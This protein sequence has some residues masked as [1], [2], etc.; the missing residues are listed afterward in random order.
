[1]AIPIKETPVLYGKDAESFLMEAEKSE[2][3]KKDI[4]ERE[5]IMSFFDKVS[6]SSKKS[7]LNLI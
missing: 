2:K 6:S 1:M 5:R 4:S 3:Q 7:N